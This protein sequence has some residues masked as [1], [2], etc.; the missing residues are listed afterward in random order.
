MT[1]A[2]QGHSINLEGKL[3][4]EAQ[5]SGGSA[6]GQLTDAFTDRLNQEP[7]FADVLQ[8]FVAYTHSKETRARELRFN[9]K[10]H[11]YCSPCRM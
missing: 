10:S 5:I 11:S 4:F 7:T 8:K 2:E 1:M 6:F 3:G 9:G